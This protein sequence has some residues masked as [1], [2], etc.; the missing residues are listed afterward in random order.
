V[1]LSATRFGGWAIHIWLW[2]NNPGGMFTNY[3][4]SVPQCEGSIY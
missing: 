1:A 3:N 4:A 2:E